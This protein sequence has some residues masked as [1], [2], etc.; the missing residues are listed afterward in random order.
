MMLV[1]QA[2]WETGAGATTHPVSC[3]FPTEVVLH[4]SHSCLPE[5]G[6]WWLFHWIQVNHSFIHLP[7]RHALDKCMRAGHKSGIYILDIGEASS[8]VETGNKIIAF[9]KEDCRESRLWVPAQR[10]VSGHR[11]GSPNPSLH[12]G[13]SAEPCLVLLTLLSI[14]GLALPV[15]PSRFKG[16][17]YFRRSVHSSSGWAHRVQGG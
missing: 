7:T 17:A 3:V 2:S 8:H 13:I 4:L 14:C 10:H 1:V 15:C 12:Y 5:C 9:C 16:S 11:L 6:H